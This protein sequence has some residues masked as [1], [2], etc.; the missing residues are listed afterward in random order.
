MLY[1]HTI[2]C[3]ISSIYYIDS[4][5]LI[6]LGYYREGLRTVSLSKGRRGSS[7]GYNHHRNPEEDYRTHSTET[8]TPLSLQTRR[9]SSS[10]GVLSSNSGNCTIN[11][12]NAG[13]HAS[14]ANAWSTF[15]IFNGSPEME[16]SSL[17]YDGENEGDEL[18]HE[19]CGY[20]L[21]VWMVCE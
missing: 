12:S 8:R 2:Y 5:V 3:T 6:K 7:P 11:T 20:N 14:F 4:M 1:F 10:A 18:L 16:L 21:S 15:H 19:M 13:N 9:V 17:E